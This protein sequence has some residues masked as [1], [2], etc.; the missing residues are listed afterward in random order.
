MVWRCPAP[1]PLHHPP[2]PPHD[3]KPASLGETL[4]AKDRP[5]QKSSHGGQAYSE[6]GQ[7]LPLENPETRMGVRLALIGLPLNL[8]GMTYFIPV[9]ACFIPGLIFCD[10]RFCYS[11]SLSFNEIRRR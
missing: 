1:S 8:H 9:L 11:N 2:A 10:L 6:T 3:G 7:F 5:A 4:R